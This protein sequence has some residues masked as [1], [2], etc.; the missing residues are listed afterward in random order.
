MLIHVLQEFLTSL[1][2]HAKTH[3]LQFPESFVP[4]AGTYHRII[5]KCLWVYLPPSNDFH[6][7]A[8]Q[9]KRMEATEIFSLDCTDAAETRPISLPPEL[10]MIHDRG[11]NIQEYFLPV[12]AEHSAPVLSKIEAFNSCSIARTVQTPWLQATALYVNVS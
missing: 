12:I 11:L 8:Q 10:H 1:F 4:F 7:H 2:F 5:P 3:Q 6:G 9:L